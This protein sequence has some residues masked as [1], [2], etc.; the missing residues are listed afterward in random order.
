MEDLEILLDD[1]PVTGFH[2]RKSKA[3]LCYL[4]VTATPHSRSAL[5]GLLWGDLPETA[6]RANLRK[7]LSNLRQLVAPY[8]TIHHA[9][10]QMNRVVQSSLDVADFEA[11]FHSRLGTA[12]PD[13]DELER[14]VTHYT[15]DF[16]SGFDLRNADEFEF[17]VL[18]QRARLHQ[19]AIDGLD[20]LVQHYAVAGNTATA[21]GYAKRLIA[22]EPW[23]E[24]SHRHLMRLLAESG[25][26]SAALMQYETCRELLD[27]ELGVQPSQ[28][29]VSVWQAICRDEYPSTATPADFK[30]HATVQRS[31]IARRHVLRQPG[32][33]IGREADLDALYKLLME[34][35]VQLL[36]VVGAGGMGKTHLAMATLER[37][38]TAIGGTPFAD[39]VHFVSLAALT[40]ASDLIPA[41]AQAL[42]FSFYPG[43]LPEEQ[44]LLYLQSR[45]LLLVLDNYEQLLPDVTFIQ[46]LLHQ[47][48]GIRL[49]VTSR[50][51]L[52]LQNEQLYPLAVLNFPRPT[53]E[54]EVVDPPALQESDAAQLFIHFARRIRPAYEWKEA[55]WSALQR[56][57]QLTSGMP[58]ALKLAATWMETLSP[59]EI[60]QEIDDRISSS[61]DFLAADLQDLPDRHRS[62][63]AVFDSAWSQL[64]ADEQK[65]LMALS[66]F[67]DGFTRQAAEA[68]T[69]A[70]LPA[71]TVLVSKSFLQRT[72]DGRYVMHELL[73]RYAEVRLTAAESNSDTLR[74][75][76]SAYFCGDLKAHEHDW[77]H[78][79]QV[80]AF[81]AMAADHEN[82][83]IA[84]RWAAT[85]RQPL[86]LMQA[87]ESMGEFYTW[88]ARYAEGEAIFGFA[89][90]RLA[91]YRIETDHV[92]VDALLAEVR[93]L[94]WQAEFSREFLGKKE[95]AADLLAQA[96]T[97]LDDPS[98]TA[99]DVR[100]ERAR[101]L[102][103]LA[104]VARDR[105]DHGTDESLW[106]ESLRLS[107]ELGDSEWAT[108]KTAGLGWMAL[109]AGNHEDAYSHFVAA[110][111]Q[112]QD[113]GNTLYLSNYLAGLG[114]VS[115]H[116]GDLAEGE[117]FL[118]EAINAIVRTQGRLDKLVNLH[119]LL[120]TTLL[121]SGK[122]DAAQATIDEGIELY[123][124]AARSNA[125]DDL[126][127]TKALLLTH[128]GEY[129]EAYEQAQG[130][131]RRGASHPGQAVTLSLLG[132]ITLAQ[133]K[134]VESEKWLSKSLQLYKQLGQHTRQGLP[135]TL[136]AVVQQMLGRPIDALTCL[137]QARD[138][139]IAE[140][141]F[142]L[143]LFFFPIAAWLLASQGRDQ[144][145]RECSEVTTPYRFV[146]ESRWFADVVDIP[147]HSDG[148]PQSHPVLDDPPGTPRQ[149]IWRKAEG[150]SLVA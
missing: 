128:M 121:Y 133:E 105:G 116:R 132:Q 67:R 102:I 42:N 79:R 1:A 112:W 19:L 146:M 54:N 24:E 39:G 22:T 8:L 147:L 110:R 13:M 38:E 84:W 150:L 26:R 69:N 90:E 66:V 63:R 16:L 94:A 43:G 103:Q 5:A 85:R 77:K 64:G 70:S 55:D 45:R 74:D 59:A 118:R 143:I 114:T 123:T 10:V 49:L 137:H 145:A 100:R 32:P 92:T 139:L 115:L 17:W 82:L 136:L 44:L 99:Y 124:A 86:W 130:V 144:L 4:A 101:L 27:A 48:P 134:Y 87:I 40:E 72:T 62:M 34:P 51:K 109:R 33:L 97:L 3:M 65:L 14:A 149:S 23:R 135:L 140:R 29:T 88:E 80:A 120:G 7:V 142:P 68:V 15:G 60:A 28:Q 117:A 91:A 57:C 73:H 12:S 111:N 83:R 46:A 41:V 30:H 56:I 131:Y 127:N 107:E 61:L 75:H 52:N 95:M 20:S 78:G 93:L 89:A 2:S 76:H 96:Q 108:Y 6:A 148:R 129:G 122:F 37:L 25:E 119:H 47:A 18:S 81:A 125:A 50:L 58:L 11:G 9:D 141:S 31:Q 98:L 113:Q 106:R 53:P 126:R 71:L 21:I 138:L 36:T 104:R 35:N